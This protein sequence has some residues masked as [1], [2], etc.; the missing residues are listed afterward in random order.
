MMD[1]VRATGLPPGAAAFLAERTGSDR[2]GG[3]ALAVDVALAPGG[4]D[5]LRARAAAASLVLTHRL[6]ARLGAGQQAGM[7][8]QAAR[9]IG[10]TARFWLG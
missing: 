2:F 4:A 5:H 6:R 8:E 9:V 10:L 3:R 1:A 7:R